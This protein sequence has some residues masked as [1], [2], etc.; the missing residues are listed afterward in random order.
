M[1][2]GSLEKMMMDVLRYCDTKE[3]DL[4]DFKS[5]I[6]SLA[7]GQAKERGYL[8]NDY[9]VTDKGRKFYQNK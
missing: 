6:F 8:T 1:S 5:E 4:P 2:E 3:G 7:I 9:K